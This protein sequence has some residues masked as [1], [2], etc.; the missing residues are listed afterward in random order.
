MVMTVGLKNTPRHGAGVTA[1]VACCRQRDGRNGG[2]AKPL[3]AASRA[4]CL[5]AVLSKANIKS[6]NYMIWTS[7]DIDNYK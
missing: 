1:A 2:T 7:N 4:R 3:L 6:V 5:A